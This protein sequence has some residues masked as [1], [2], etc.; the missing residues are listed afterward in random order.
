MRY[1]LILLLFVGCS[2]SKKEVDKVETIGDRFARHRFQSMMVL[3][4]E[5]CEYLVSSS[6]TT[7]S[8]AHKGNCKSNFHKR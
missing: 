1:L 6:S 7:F 5:G 3:E 8:V 2:S 4:L